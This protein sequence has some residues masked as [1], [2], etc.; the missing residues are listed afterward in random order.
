MMVAL[1]AAVGY[2]LFHF[3]R[4]VE[5]AFSFNGGKD[6][7]VLSLPRPSSRQLK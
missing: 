1:S 5:L 7:T 4:F 2:C 6:S 3:F